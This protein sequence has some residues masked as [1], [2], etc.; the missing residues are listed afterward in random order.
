MATSQFD[1]PLHVSGSMQAF[2]AAA[3]GSPVADPNSDAGPSLFYQGTGVLDPR[4]VYL[5]D[6]VQGYT[7]V[8]Q[9]FQAQNW[10]KSVGQIP[11]A[12]S[13]SNIASVAG[14]TSGTA[15]AFANASLGVTRNVP[16]RPFASS[17]MG[18]APA[19]AGVALDF[20]FAF[21]NCTAGSG[22]ITVADSRAFVPG[23]PLVIGGVGNAAG[24]APLLTQVA[25]LA[26]ATTITVNSQ[27]IPLATNATA[28]IGT[29]D[30]WGPSPMGFPM[31]QAAYPFLAGGPGLFLDPRQAIARA[32][33]ITGVA[34]GTGGAIT[35][36]GWDIYGQPMRETITATAGATTTFGKKAFKYIGSITPAF[37]DAHAYTVGTT[38]VFGFAFR[39]TLWEDTEV[40]WNGASMTTSQGWL[41][42]D[43][44]DPATGTTGDVRGVI[45]TGAGGGGTGIGAN[46]SNG[47]VSGLA[48]SGR[49]LEMRSL[50]NI[51]S[52]LSASPASPQGMFGATQFAG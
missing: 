25:T 18:A 16:I 15:F 7:G 26:S 23:M 1:G 29:G 46:A 49:R 20:G 22:T 35:V 34:A 24:T 4:I 38:D 43:L 52:M 36:A 3:F 31:P 41:A 13:A 40:Y 44:T 5:K 45:Q 27:A 50:I 51:M 11:A 21:G 30:L 14:T 28:P 42:A 2:L 48:M 10:L 47:T 19:V 32:V 39:S 37:T 6:K 9:G 12:L 17:L 33:Q 8:V